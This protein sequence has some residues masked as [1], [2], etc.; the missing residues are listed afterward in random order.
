[1][2]PLF[3]SVLSLLPV[4]TVLAQDF[5]SPTEIA[6]K[7]NLPSST[8]LTFPTQTVGSSD[9]QD[10]FKA[11]DWGISKKG[12]ISNDQDV[13]FVQDPFNNTDTS[14]VL[15]VLYP[16]GS[17]SNGTGGT[18]FSTY[19]NDSGTGF[20]TIQLSYQVGFDTG[21]DFVKGGKLPGLRGG[22]LDGCDGGANSDGCFSVR[23]MWRTSGQ[24][25]A[26]AYV[27]G[28]DALCKQSDV[29]CNDSGYGTSIDR[30]VF[31]FVAGTWNQV[32][33]VVGLNNPVS[34]SNG[35][36][37]TYYNGALAVNET[38]LQIRS[39]SSVP[40]IQGIFFSTFFGGSDSSWA[41]PSNQS[42]YY[43][44]IQMFASTSDSTMKSSAASPLYRTSGGQTMVGALAAL[45]VLVVGALL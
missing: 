31:S 28:N 32:D 22:S 6:S 29:I 12:H 39:S 15:A 30:G 1:M 24:G 35:F 25:E 18:T 27:Q 5:L 23:F 36:I 16:A 34:K 42:T 38:G 9:V 19:Y 4:S 2:N 40:S 41:S 7:F 11:S 45:S 33:M 8:S 10:W 21:F 20:G 17:Y 13:S 43:K 3:L 14:P 26:Y 44:D 37:T